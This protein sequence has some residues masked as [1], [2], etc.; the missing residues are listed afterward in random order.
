M[1]LKQIRQR[2]EETK[3]YYVYKHLKKGTDIVFY[4][5]KGSM[6]RANTHESRNRWWHRIVNKH[7][8]DVEIISEWE[9][10]QTAFQEE[11][12][13]IAHYASLGVVL[14]NRTIGGAGV[15]LTLTPA[16]HLLNFMKKHALSI[17]DMRTLLETELVPSI[18]LIKQKKKPMTN[19]ERQRAL[20]QRLK[21]LK[22]K[23]T[24]N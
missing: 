11:I 12:K 13:W 5:G 17:D 24:P 8:F 23:Q 22:D 16:D 15:I 18:P 20:R 10:E 3:K 7:G 4:I 19:A 14:C 1:T 9:D 21:L 6:T 2:I